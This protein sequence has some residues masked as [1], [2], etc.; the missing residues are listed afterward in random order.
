MFCL[1]SRNP[2]AQ[3]VLAVV[4]D[5]ALRASLQFAL[6]IEGFRVDA[7]ASGEELL[8]QHPLPE[9]ACLIVDYALPAVDGIDISVTLR[10]R[11]FDF[12][13]ILMATDP[14]EQ[15]RHRISAEKL[16]LVEK[17]LLGGK[18]AEAVRQA[19]ARD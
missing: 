15:L 6:E 8:A 12:P 13:T 19:F 14:P 9:Q 4:N 10:R 16:S 5:P 17:P 18:L 3:I 11:G 1:I 7:Y 2:V